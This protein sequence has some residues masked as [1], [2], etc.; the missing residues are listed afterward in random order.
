MSSFDARTTGRPDTWVIRRDG[1]EV[2]MLSFVPDAIALPQ[3]HVDAI[4]RALNHPTPPERWQS[5]AADMLA[6][7]RGP[8]RSGP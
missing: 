4:I 1:V 3:L 8:T 7:R 6:R 2:G 5:P